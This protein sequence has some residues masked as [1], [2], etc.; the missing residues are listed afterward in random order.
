MTRLSAWIR[1]LFNV[2][3]LSPLS[4]EG[5]VRLPPC[6]GEIIT[7]ENGHEICLVLEDITIGDRNWTSKLGAFLIVTQPKIGDPLPV[8]PVCGAFWVKIPNT[9]H[10]RGRGWV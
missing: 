10:V 8:C 4:V 7:C 6:K 1:H 9:L 5:A 3:P 2:K